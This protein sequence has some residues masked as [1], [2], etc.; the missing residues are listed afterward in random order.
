MKKYSILVIIYLISVVASSI[1]NSLDVNIQVIYRVPSLDIRWIDVAIIYIIGN[2]F[3]SFFGKKQVLKSNMIIVPLCFIYLLFEFF[4]LLISWHVIDAQT[5]ISLFLATLSFFI[6]IDLST[7]KI[8]QEEIIQFIKKISL[9]ASIAVIISNFYLFYLF[10]KGQVVFADA[11]IRIALD[12]TGGKESV[13]TSV[14]TPFVYGFA[15]YF[16]RK[17]N[18]FWQKLVFAAA[19]LSIFVSVVTSFHRGTLFIVAAITLYVIISSKKAQ[20]VFSKIVGFALLL[21]VGYFMFGSILRDKGYDPIEKIMQ[22]ASYAA[23]V[24]DPDWDKGRTGVQEYALAAWRNHV[25]TGV[26]YDDLNNYGLPVD[27]SSAHNGIIT[28]LFHRGI[29]GTALL[30]CIFIVIYSYLIKLW[31]LLRNEEDE[32]KDII[33]M[34][35]VVAVLWIVPFL[36]QE[37]MWEKYGLSMQFLYFGLIINFYK[38]QKAK[39]LKPPPFFA[40]K[41]ES[42]ITI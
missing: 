33:R 20:Q 32:T 12:V 34:L 18:E 1:A 26:G 40:Q 6:I 38:Q 42:R 24:N 4:Q 37:V 23:D 22:T 10:T 14:L 5:Q 39:L 31:R 28:S 27:A 11:G 29:I 9:W 30:L 25:W 15:L 41:L 2:Y 13:T 16:I 7:F 8:P 35:I 36:T 3:Y 19:I 21:G 17:K